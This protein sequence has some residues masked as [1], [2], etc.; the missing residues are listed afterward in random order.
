MEQYFYHEASKTTTWDEPA[1]VTP[2]FEAMEKQQM[3]DRVWEKVDADGNGWLDR[4]EVKALLRELGDPLV[5][6]NKN[7]NG[8]VKKM[9]GSR[10]MT[11]AEMM[12]IK[13]AVAKT[14]V[15]RVARMRFAI[16][17]RKEKRCLSRHLWRRVNEVF[18]VFH[19]LA[20]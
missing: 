17:K 16:N 8:T 1:E 3:L 15:V 7:L 19:N 18:K 2:V 14:K 6:W 12:E 5:S 20:P 4:E 9:V 10:N 13:K 11:V